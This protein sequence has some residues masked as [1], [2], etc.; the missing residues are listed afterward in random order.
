QLGRRG[1]RHAMAQ[2]VGVGNRPLQRLHAAE[3]AADHRGPAVDPQ[4]V[5]QTGLTVDP[6]L[7]HDHRE[8]GAPDLAG[9]R[10]DARRAGGAVTAAE[11]VQRNDEETVGVDGL[12]GAD[13]GI[14]PAGLAVV[15][16][17]V[18]G[19]VVMAG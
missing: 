19:G 11:V 14:P 2:P 10:I 15:F 3:A 9:F 6:V 7:H 5:G 1:N 16:A 4:V 13:T 18:A 17:V 8:V 12:A